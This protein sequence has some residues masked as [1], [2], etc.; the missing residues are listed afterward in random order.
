MSQPKPK[1][2]LP[3]GEDEGRRSRRWA[4]CCVR[5]HL[6]VCACVKNIYIPRTRHLRFSI[7]VW[8]H[9]CIRRADLGLWWSLPEEF[10]TGQGPQVRRRAG[11]NVSR[12]RAP[13]P[14]RRWRSKDRSLSGKERKTIQLMQYHVEAGN[15]QG[16]DE[17][18][19]NRQRGQEG[20]AGPMNLNDCAITASAVGSLHIKSCVVSLHSCNNLSDS[21][22]LALSLHVLSYS[23]FT[24]GFFFC[25]T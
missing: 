3:W 14:V 10:F 5:Q 13:P 12:A 2:T 20:W 6:R 9:I 17:A 24:L 18:V 19:V 7:Q 11:F 22:L 4:L 1:I 23:P 21:W 16:G 25:L 8:L 15:Y